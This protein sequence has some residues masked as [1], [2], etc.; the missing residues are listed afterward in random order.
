[1]LKFN[2]NAV[3]QLI[4]CVLLLV[5]TA[6]VGFAEISKY[7]TYFDNQNYNHAL[8]K[9]KQ[10]QKIET[11]QLKVVEKVRV[12]AKSHKT[13]LSATEIDSLAYL[14]YSLQFKYE[15]INPD[16]ICSYISAESG[17]KKSAKSSANAK[18]LMQIINST[19][20]YLAVREGYT[21]IDNIETLLYNPFINVKLGCR[22]IAELSSKHGLKGGIVGY[23]SGPK[24]AGIYNR[25]GHIENIPVETQNYL[26]T[27]LNYYEKYRIM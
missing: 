8:D 23:N 15:N 2:S 9:I 12:I 1:M 6:Y 17:W 4:G 14:I 26:P 24:Y 27:V 22:Y 7:D 16:L 20:A 3:K 18:G 19:G 10:I 13:N 5:F 21:D 25:Q 11:E